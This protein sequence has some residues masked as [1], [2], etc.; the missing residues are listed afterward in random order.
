MAAQDFVYEGM[1]VRDLSGAGRGPVVPKVT[2]VD[3]EGGPAGAAILGKVGIDPAASIATNQ[4]TVTTAATLIV[5]A[6]AGRQ[7][8]VILNEGTTDV[9]I[10]GSGVTTATGAL[11]T[12]VKGAGLVIDSAAAVYGIVASGTQVVSYLESY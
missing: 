11:L 3:P 1:A 5:A 9:R 4:V 6:R 2:L 8:V 10:G 12:G 7:S